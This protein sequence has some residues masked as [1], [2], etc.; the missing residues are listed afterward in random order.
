L[1]ATTAAA[2]LLSAGAAQAS[3]IYSYRLSNVDGAV[4]GTVTGRIFLPDGDG[5]LAAS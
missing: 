2:G 3:T 1:I 5:T 4:A